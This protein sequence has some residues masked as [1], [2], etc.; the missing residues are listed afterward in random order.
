MDTSGQNEQ[1]VGNIVPEGTQ[2]PK[3][4]TVSSGGADIF[5]SG[6]IM[7]DRIC[8]TDDKAESGKRD[9]TKGDGIM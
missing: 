4:K 9:V 1:L 3:R 8:R 2:R 5:R 7:L 6:A